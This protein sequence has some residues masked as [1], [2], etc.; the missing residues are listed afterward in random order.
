MT[1]MENVK[2]QTR[3]IEID[4]TSSSTTVFVRKNIKK[5]KEIDPVFKT[6]N[7]VYVY[8][9]YQYTFQEWNKIITDNIK[10]EGGNL[11]CQ[12]DITQLAMSEMMDMIGSMLSFNTLSISENDESPKPLSMSFLNN[13]SAIAMMY[14]GM[15]NRGLITLESVIDVYKDEVELYLEFLKE[16][17][18]KE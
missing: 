10:E 8:D 13:F 9:E 17:N 16:E 12:I 7:T 5:I 6:E 3:P 15:I 14:G 4:D 18:N 11:Q 2:S 1:I